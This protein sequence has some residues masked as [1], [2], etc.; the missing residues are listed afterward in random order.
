MRLAETEGVVRGVVLRPHTRLC[1][2][3]GVTG[4][5]RNGSPSG[6]FFAEST[7]LGCSVRDRS[8]AYHAMATSSLNPALLALKTETTLAPSPG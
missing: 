6:Q 8:H 2:Q 3:V 1:W 4:F 7:A 5:G